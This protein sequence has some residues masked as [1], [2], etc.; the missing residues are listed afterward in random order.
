MPATHADIG[1][2]GF[3]V[4]GV[5]VITAARAAQNLSIPASLLTGTLADAR[6]AA[7]N[8]TQHQAALAISWGQITT[9]KPT[10]LAGYGIT[11]AALAS[12]THAFADL[13]AKPTTVAGYGITDT[14][15]KTESD[16]AFA[17]L[18]HSHSAAAI[19]SGTLGFAR[20][21]TGLGT[22]GTAGQ[23][24]R[25][26]ALATALEY[27]TAATDA[28]ASIANSAGTVQFSASGADTLR[29]AAGSGMGV[30]YDAATKTVTFSYTGSGTGVT[31][32]YS[33]VAVGATSAPASGADTINFAA[34]G[35]G[36]T[37]GLNATT[38]VLTY[39]LD[40]T[41]LS[42]ATTQL[43]GNLP[44]ARFNAG[45]GASNT[46]FWR[47]DGTWATVALDLAANYAWT[48]THSWT[49][50]ATFSSTRTT[51][52]IRAQNLIGLYT[53]VTDSAA[54][55][56]YI[57][58]YNVLLGSGTDQSMAY[59]ANTGNGHCWAIN[60]SSTRA[61]SLD[62]T[63]RLLIDTTVTALAS[64][65]SVPAGGIVTKNGVG[66]YNVNAAG[67]GALPV[68]STSPLNRTRVHMNSASAL[69]FAGAVL[70]GAA[71]GAYSGKLPVSFDDGTVFYIPIYA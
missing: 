9:G 70:S 38:K 18:G 29:M 69:D 6:V 8:V 48:G 68:I 60:G 43:T 67:T 47:G 58:R 66:L 42:I 27:V 45:T 19:T 41:A 34:S 16:A 53:D 7:S 59:F 52:Q 46:T 57:T 55:T 39:T 63:G 65:G 28:F 17:P 51:G 3:M 56:G 54:L 62:S 10:T 15:T 49:Q 22:L 1:A 12:H 25:V 71:L 32:A 30:A 33:V 26:N 5:E 4:G 14:Y 24:L 44:I 36:L 11:D 35:T 23:I 50:P 13:T 21:G 20:G 40:Q 31:D 37:A 61:M 64:G 2:R